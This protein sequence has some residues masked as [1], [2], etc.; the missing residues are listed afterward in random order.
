M[1]SAMRSLKPVLYGAGLIK[2]T[3]MPCGAN[4]ARMALPIASRACFVIAYGPNPGAAST[5]AIEDMMMTRPEP[6]AAMR[7][8][9]ACVTATV[10]KTLTS[11]TLRR[12]SFGTSDIGPVCPYPALLMRTSTSHA[13]IF[14]MSEELVMSTFSTCSPGCSA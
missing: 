5:P 3:S 1:E 13:E 6:L 7:G 11:N 14:A 9:A 4:S 8:K 12:R 2:H 10:P